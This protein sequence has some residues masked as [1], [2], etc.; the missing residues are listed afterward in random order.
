MRALLI[1]VLLVCWAGSAPARAQSHPRLDWS[2]VYL[3]GNVGAAINASDLSAGVAPGTTYF[4]TSDPA[5]IAAAGAGT[6][7]QSGFTGG[8]VGGYNALFGNILIGLEAG[9]NAFDFDETHA[10][11]ATYISAPANQF[12]LT[13]TVKSNWIATVRPRLG[14]AEDNWLV[15]VTGGLAL[16]RVDLDVAFSDN[17]GTAGGARGAASASATKA[18]WT[19]GAGGEYA[20]MPNW[21]LTAQYLFVDFGSVDAATLVTNPGPA[22]V[23]KSSIIDSTA[24]LRTNLVLVGATYRFNDAPLP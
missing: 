12:T 13:Q 8:V 4:D 5:Q 15:Y 17:F 1:T 6:P 24:D 20:L 2:G 9:A 11:M 7:T 14:W 18:G 16:T 23:G 19:L 22:L 21:S 3:G 10:T